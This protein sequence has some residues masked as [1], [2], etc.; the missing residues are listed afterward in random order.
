MYRY[1]KK[2]F[3]KENS[4]LDIVLRHVQS[5]KFKMVLVENDARIPPV[6]VIK[7]G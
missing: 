5:D 7:V 4:G 1:E 2:D 3:S 6:E